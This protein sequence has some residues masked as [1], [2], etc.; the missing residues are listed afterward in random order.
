LAVFL[1][2]TS[3]TLAA[4]LNEETGTGGVARWLSQDATLLVIVGAILGLS[5][6]RFVT[7]PL[8]VGRARAACYT[9]GV[10]VATPDLL[11]LL[12]GGTVVEGVAWSSVGTYRD[13]SE[14]VALFKRG[15][16]FPTLRIPVHDETQRTALLK[17]LDDRGITRAE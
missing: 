3:V 4:A 12:T 2:G 1:A 14:H 11:G 9:S 13:S 7:A 15:R 6:V 5:L 17:V 10:V 8:R 16:S